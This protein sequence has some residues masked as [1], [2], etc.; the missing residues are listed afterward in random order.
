MKID[1]LYIYIIFEQNFENSISSS[2]W[3]TD[4]VTFMYKTTYIHTD[5]DKTESSSFTKRE[6]ERGET[7]HKKE[8]HEDDLDLITYFSMYI[9]MYK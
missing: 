5:V 3:L 1:N 4:H 2:M 9:Y 8:T 6:R 7:E